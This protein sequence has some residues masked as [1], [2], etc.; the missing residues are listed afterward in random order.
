MNIRESIIS[1]YLAALEM[2]KQNILAC[3]E[4]V[5]FD[6][7][8]Q[9]KSS[10]IA[11]H[12]LYWI[13]MYLQESEQAFQPWSGHREEY[14]LAGGGV[15]GPIEPATKELVLDYLAFCQ[16]QVVEKVS[17]MDLDVLSAYE[18]VPVT[19]FELQL[20]SLRHIMQH[21][22]E[23]LERLGARAS[24]EGDWVA[25]RPVSLNT[26]NPNLPA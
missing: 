26:Q 21:V 24:I 17:T 6:P 2:L 16:V 3:P 10:Q 12:A 7:A 5:W 11:Y 14:R 9:N 19:M 22:G 18:W 15:E 25:T 23:L 8:D 20:Y 4:A 1:Q 13:H